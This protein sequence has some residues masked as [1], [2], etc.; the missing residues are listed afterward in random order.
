MVPIDVCWD[1]GAV[2]RTQCIRRE[3]ADVIG[4]LSPEAKELCRQGKMRNMQRRREELRLARLAKRRSKAR[5]TSPT[6]DTCPY[7]QC[8]LSAR[9]YAQ[10][11]KDKHD[12]RINDLF[13][14]SDCN[15]KVQAWQ[16]LSRMRLQDAWYIRGLWPSA[17][18]T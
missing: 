15:Y 6:T 11:K 10:Y 17:N 1:V 2:W 7:A 14:Y 16:Y 5:K 12:K 18:L 4:T 9:M 3:L 8:T 13:I